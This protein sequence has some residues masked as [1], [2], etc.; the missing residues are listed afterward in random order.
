MIASLY[1]IDF[2]D[3]SGNATRLLDIGDQLSAMIQFCATQQAQAYISLGSPWGG[4]SAAGGARRPLSWT[5]GVEHS[6][7]AEAA[8]YAIRHP[9]MIPLARDGKLRV[10]VSGGE[11]WDLLDAVILNSQVAADTDGDFFTLATYQAEAGLSLPIAG[12]AHF[13]GMPTAWILSTHTAQTLQTAS[14]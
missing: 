7:H 2:I 6:S 9:A 10:C 4:T 11:T 3:S 5:R 14:V 8:G 12:L 1:Q 13:S